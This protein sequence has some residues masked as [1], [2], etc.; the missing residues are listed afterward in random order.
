MNQG[1]IRELE[2]WNKVP[3]AKRRQY[4]EIYGEGVLRMILAGRENSAKIE[5]K[6]AARWAYSVIGR[7]PGEFSTER[8]MYAPIEVTIKDGK[9]IGSYV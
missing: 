2:R 8:E 6:L 7:E 3:L 9:A 4:A 1:V 5:A